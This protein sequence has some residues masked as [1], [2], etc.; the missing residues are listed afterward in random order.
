MQAQSH[1]NEGNM[2]LSGS[3]QY[4]ILVHCTSGLQFVTAEEILE[5]FPAAKILSQYDGL[6]Q[7]TISSYT[8][9]EFHLEQLKRL[10][11]VEKISLFLG[12]ISNFPLASA[13]N[14]NQIR[15]AEII[16]PF[17]GSSNADQW[18]QALQVIFEEKKIQILP[19]ASDSTPLA[20]FN[21]GVIYSTHCH[22][23][24]PIIQSDP[25]AA[26][27]NG[28]SAE[29]I[30]PKHQQHLFQS[31]A[32]IEAFNSCIKQ[33]FYRWRSNYKHAV[34]EFNINIIG[35]S[36]LL[37]VLLYD[38]LHVRNRLE[39][40]YS[41]VTTLNHSTAYSMC[42][43]AKVANNDVV[44]DPFGGLSTI[45]VESSLYC[46][47][48][49]FYIN[50]DLDFSCIKQAERLTKSLKLTNIEHLVIDAKLLPFSN[51]SISLVISD[52]PFGNR[53]GNYNINQSLYPA[54]LN[55][56]V[57]VVQLN[58]FIYLLTADSKLLHRTIENN[59]HVQLIQHIVVSIGGARAVLFK[60]QKVI[61]PVIVPFSQ[62]Q[63]LRLQEKVRQKLGKKK[64]Q[65]A[66]QPY[67]KQKR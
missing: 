11:S 19:S 44:L 2:A 7:F 41:A 49:A 33:R 50:G 42:R 38:D 58:G 15:P 25:A 23:T 12:A 22:R 61:N 1:A 34:V 27:L 32:V 60:L 17:L 29:I 10:R 8:N 36:A 48:K 18:Q 16:Q 55:S 63:I 24:F 28:N 46:N 6:V 35:H 57:R 21:C 26:L 56:C 59:K 40:G 39:S 43:Y 66:E 54:M 65:A 4:N 47:N 9:A 45:C 51:N 62:E 5:L 20:G 14:S 31:P 3:S 30:E 52:P 13:T 67:K 64:E 53:H 37:S